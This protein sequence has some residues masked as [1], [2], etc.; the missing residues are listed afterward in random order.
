MGLDQTIFKCEPGDVYKDDDGD[1]RLNSE[2]IQYFRKVPAL[3]AFMEA[4]WN[5]A[6]RK[7]VSLT[8]GATSVADPDVPFN[9]LSFEITE[10]VLN[11]L[12]D[13]CE[14][15]KL[16][17]DATGFFWGRHYD[18]DYAAI[19]EACIKVKEALSEGHRVWY[20]SWW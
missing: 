19:K 5:K 7:T 15:K 1:E 13:A 17:E 2:E 14:R 11:R 10:D 8:T 9:C 6:G 18:E 20:D 16:P 4:E 3:Q 12:M